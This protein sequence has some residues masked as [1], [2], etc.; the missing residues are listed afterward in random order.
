MATSEEENVVA[1]G[2]DERG[3]SHI[4]VFSINSVHCPI[5]AQAKSTAPN[6]P[7]PRAKDI[8]LHRSLKRMRDLNYSYEDNYISAGLFLVDDND[9]VIFPRIYDHLVGIILEIRGIREN[10]SH[11]EDSKAKTRTPQSPTIR[12]NSQTLEMYFGIRWLLLNIWNR[13]SERL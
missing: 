13:T 5:Q 7:K 3:S 1:S 12:R 11:S 8:L 4:A 2:S 6:V 10:S 9:D